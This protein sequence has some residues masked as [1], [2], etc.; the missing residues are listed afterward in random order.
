M[1]VI[2]PDSPTNI[3]DTYLRFREV[4][5]SLNEQLFPE[6]GKAGMQ[7]CARALGFWGKGMMIFDE[8]DDV[9]VRPDGRH[10]SRRGS[11]PY[12]AGP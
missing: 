6:I 7:E 11:G 5:R 10:Q 4:Q 9:S 1:C 3:R 2:T 8:G 12:S